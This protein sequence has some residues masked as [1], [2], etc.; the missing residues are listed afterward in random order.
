MRHAVIP[1][2][3]LF[4]A[5]CTGNDSAAPLQTDRRVYR[6]DGE[7]LS[8]GA[9]YTNR[10]DTTVQ[11]AVSGCRFPAFTLE[12]L[13]DEAWIL[14]AA[15]I[16]PAILLPPVVLR[17]GQSHRDTLWVHADHFHGTERTGTYRLVFD[18]AEGTADSGPFREMLPLEARISNPFEIVE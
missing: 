15:P 18:V 8:V 1:L 17:P 6:F 10:T 2:L 13:T 3:C 5:C 4:L 7:S 16:C 11:V 14:A 12:R 9:V